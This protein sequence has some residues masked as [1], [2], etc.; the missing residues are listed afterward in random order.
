MT[1]PKLDIA[2]VIDLTPVQVDDVGRLFISPVIHDWSIVAQRGIDTVV[3][4]GAPRTIRSIGLDC[5]QNQR[6]WIF[7]PRTVDFSVS[8]DGERWEV[9]GRWEQP[10]ESSSEIRT[11]V[12]AVPVD[13]APARFVRVVA[14]GVDPLPEWHLAAGRP[15]W[16]FADEIIVEE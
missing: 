5:M 6:V 7:F 2:D 13:A 15:G 10:V 16:I 9:V 14:R 12:I 11:A 1:D 8:E 4:L 3:D